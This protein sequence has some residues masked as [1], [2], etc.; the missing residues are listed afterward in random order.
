M[1]MKQFSRLIEIIKKDL[2]K[3]LSVAY[4]PLVE[5]KATFFRAMKIW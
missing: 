4:D 3:D 1:F 5:V 2:S